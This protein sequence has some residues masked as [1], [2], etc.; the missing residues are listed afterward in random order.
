[1]DLHRERY[2]NRRLVQTGAPPGATRELSEADR[3]RRLEY[4]WYMLPLARIAKGYSAI[5]NLLGRVGPV[6]EGMSATSALKNDWFSNRHRMIKEKLH[7]LARQFERDKGYPP[8]YW[9]LVR[10][11]RQA[12]VSIDD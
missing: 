12:S 8:P 9:E 4:D 6:P 5:L 1:L 3:G 2:D 10:L 7:H 11:A